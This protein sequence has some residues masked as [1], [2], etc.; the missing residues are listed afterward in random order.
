M[1]LQVLLPLLNGTLKAAQLI[2]R[3]HVRPQATSMP[4]GNCLKSVC[5]R[6][7]AYYWGLHGKECFP[8]FQSMNHGPRP[9]Q[10]RHGAS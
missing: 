4:H 10:K 9:P 7:A 8:K 5:V 1:S 2:H 3:Y 6:N